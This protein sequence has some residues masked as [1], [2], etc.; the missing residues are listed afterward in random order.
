M[1]NRTER[2]NPRTHRSP[3]WIYA[4]IMTFSL[5]SCRCA[6]FM[7]VVEIFFITTSLPSHLSFKEGCVVKFPCSWERTTSP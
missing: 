5:T 1:H 4:S 3:F 7:P 2:I 6:S